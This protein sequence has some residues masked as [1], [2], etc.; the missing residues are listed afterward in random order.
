[1]LNNT[2]KCENNRV[3]YYKFAVND[4]TLTRKVVVMVQDEFG[5]MSGSFNISLKRLIT[6]KGTLDQFLDY[7]FSFA[8]VKN[9]T[10]QL[11]R[12]AN[13]SNFAKC[14]T[15]NSIEEIHAQLTEYA[16][17]NNLIETLGNVEY[18]M[19]P[20]SDFRNWVKE[21]LEGVTSLKLLDSFEM[22]GLMKHNSGRRDYKRKADGERCYC[23]KKRESLQV[24][25][26][27]V[28]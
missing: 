26:K 18:C 11:R 15:G 6:C 12:D 28:A 27:E 19:I 9:I 22:L 7:G 13:T 2:I 14:H 25:E 20:T 23:I 3:V 24:V 4:Y 16:V 8:D 10:E 5:R 17:E 21:E 1:M